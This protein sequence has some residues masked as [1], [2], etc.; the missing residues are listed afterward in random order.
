M[1]LWLWAKVEM[2]RRG[3]GFAGNETSGEGAE[4][5]NIVLM[6]P[7]MASWVARGLIRPV[8]VRTTVWRA[9]RWSARQC[10]LG[11]SRRTMGSLLLDRT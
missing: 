9:F 5:T 7:D 2:G 10:V 1:Q 4:E 3:L 11:M 6:K 8:R